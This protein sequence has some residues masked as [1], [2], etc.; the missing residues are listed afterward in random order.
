M[1]LVLVFI[2]THTLCI[3]ATKAL[4][5]LRIC[6]C[7]FEPSLLDNAIYKNLMCWLKYILEQSD[8]IINNMTFMHTEDSDQLKTLTS[9]QKWSVSVQRVIKSPILFYM[10]SGD[11]DQAGWIIWLI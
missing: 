4:L 7:S 10:S 2:Y 11:Y 3:R 1:N 8:D 5:S 6:T 9:L